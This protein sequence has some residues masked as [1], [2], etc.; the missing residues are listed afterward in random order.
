MFIDRVT[1][2]V[3]AGKGG[4]GCVAFRREKYVPRGGPYGGDG[5][6][7][8]DVILLADSNLATL[9][10]FKFRP[11]VEAREGVRGKG[12]LK[13][14]ED[15]KDVC[16]KVPVGTLV[17]EVEGGTLLCDL[18]QDGMTFTAA[19]GGRGGRGNTHFATSTHQTPREAEEGGLGEHRKLLLELRVVAHVGL[20]GFPNA[21]KSTLLN[22]ISKAK[23][24]VADYP[25]TTLNPVLG[26]LKLDE[27]SQVVIADMP[28]LVEG[29]HQ[30]VG[31]GHEFLRHITRT[32]FLLFVLDMSGYAYQEPIKAF[33][34][35]LKEIELYDADLLKRSRSMV[36]NKMDLEGA[37]ENLKKFKKKFPKEKV[38]AI[39][40]LKGEGLG[41]LI[42]ELARVKTLCAQS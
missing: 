2:E 27:L 42:S 17:K 12:G 29:A 13:D 4:N 33:S 30:N 25:F 41:E 9:I 24:K 40:A 36:A 10:D 19:K 14:G 18:V 11:L 28:G 22:K 38:I 20:V 6:D 26:V 35:L 31:L 7:G 8:G 5:G 32:R 3:K 34:T 39:S 21:G 23:S 15:G 37:P 1:I 16:V